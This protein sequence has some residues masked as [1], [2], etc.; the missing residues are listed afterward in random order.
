[1][2]RWLL[3]A[4]MITLLLTGCGD[5]APERKLEELRETLRTAEEIR[6]AADL[7]ANIGSE[8]FSCALECTADDER[9][10][11]CLTAP[12]TIA[13][14][15]AVVDADGTKLEYGE[16]SL[17]VGGGA[18]TPAPVTAI[19]LLLNALR[20]GSTLRSWTEREGEQTLYVREF[21][22]TDDCTL[23]VWLDAASL[24]PVHAEFLSGGAAVLR[25]EIREFSYK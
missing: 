2:R 9:I 1:M 15:C 8:V 16:V 13:G 25:C 17:G 23:T 4:L 18:E 14:I 24:L 11:V 7:N 5:A 10:T 19:P 6:V 22:V 21:F 12:E 20:S 3:P